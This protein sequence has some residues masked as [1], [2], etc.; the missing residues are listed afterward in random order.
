MAALEV[1]PV[2]VQTHTRLLVRAQEWQ[3]RN[4]DTSLLL[5]G[6][7]LRAGESFLEGQ[8]GRDPP[9]TPLQAEYVVASRSSAR[10][11]LRVVVGGV[12]AALAVAIALAAV[13]LVQRSRAIHG[14]KVARS[15]EL[16]ALSL[17]APG[18]DWRRLLQLALGAADQ[19]ETPEA[20]DALRAQN[21]AAP[22]FVASPDAVFSGQWC[23]AVAAPMSRESRW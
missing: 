16:A 1:D 8:S 21:P 3:R 2:W 9:P 19:A 22:D 20:T 15:R 11:R 14:A 10:R 18:S 17:G 12:V 13:A 23:L 6:S 5:R 7:D 4:R